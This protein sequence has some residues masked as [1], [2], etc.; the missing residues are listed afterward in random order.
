MR[1][2]SQK[3]IYTSHIRGVSPTEAW[4]TEGRKALLFTLVD[5]PRPTP[6]SCQQEDGHMAPCAGLFTP[7]SFTGT[8]AKTL[9]AVL[10]GGRHQMRGGS[11]AQEGRNTCFCEMK[12]HPSWINPLSHGVSSQ[13]LPPVAT[14]RKNRYR[15][16]QN[17]HLERSDFSL[18]LGSSANLYSG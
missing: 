18:N 6:R 12:F 1:G 11:P 3:R 9:F 13:N 5:A 17:T 16:A 7:R 10:S 2:S 15:C 8:V 4:G 14:P